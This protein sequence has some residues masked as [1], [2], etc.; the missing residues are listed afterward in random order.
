MKSLGLEIF[1]DIWIGIVI[2]IKIL[3]HNKIEN[4]LNDRIKINNYFF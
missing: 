2:I 4:N 1:N 3:K